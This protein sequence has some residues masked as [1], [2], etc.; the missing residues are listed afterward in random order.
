MMAFKY[1]RKRL[2]CKGRAGMMHGYIAEPGEEAK[3]KCSS[4]I[5]KARSKKKLI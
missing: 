5:N 3:E 1:K 4:Y 2:I